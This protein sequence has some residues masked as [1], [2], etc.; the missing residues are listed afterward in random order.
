MPL[1]KKALRWIGKFALEILIVLAVIVAVQ[2]WRAKDML[3][4]DGS[5]EVQP[6]T[7]V[8]LAGNTVELFN[9]AHVDKTTL[10]YFFA[11]WCSIC[12]VSIGSLENLDRDKL[13]I[14]VI[15]LDY[16][17]SEE[18]QAFVDEHEM[19]FDVVMGNSAIAK[20][21]EIRGYPS[22]YL[23]NK[24][25]KV[26]GRHFGFTTSFHIKLQNWLTS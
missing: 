18:V 6:V 24:Q 25:Q 17:A 9:E 19:T 26:I 20:Q 7:A 12:S 10:V 16:Q 1:S 8:T 23:L 13:N 3:E 11:P 14:V 2:N 21:F 4:T 22:Y 5:V 15:A